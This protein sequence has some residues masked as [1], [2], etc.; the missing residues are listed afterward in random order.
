MIYQIETLLSKKYM[1]EI[2]SNKNILKI[3]N[4][5]NRNI[6]SQIKNLIIHSLF[7]VLFPIILLNH[8]LFIYV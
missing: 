2:K 5:N 1:D 3:E 4:I 6:I 7:I 8:T